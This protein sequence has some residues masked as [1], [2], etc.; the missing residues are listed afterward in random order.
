MKQMS[1]FRALKGLVTLALIA[2]GTSYASAQYYVNVMQ[3]DGTRIQ[4]S[5]DDIE[6]VSITDYKLPDFKAESVD[7]GLSVRWATC[8]IGANQANEKGWFVRWGETSEMVDTIPYKWYDLTTD[9]YTKYNLYERM[10]TVDMKYRL[11]AA[12]DV[13]NSGAGPQWRI[14]S[15][16]EFQELIDSCNWA[17]VDSGRV[18]GYLVTSKKNGNNIFL[19]TAGFSMNGNIYYPEHIGAYLSNTL[20]IV[21]NSE[22]RLLFFNLDTV[23]LQ[24]FSR[25]I[26]LSVR[27]VY[28]SDFGNNIL[29]VSGVELDTASL[30]LKAGQNYTLQ[31]TGKMPDNTTIK[32]GAVEWSTSDKNVAVVEDGQ[33]TAVGEGT[34]TITVSFGGKTASCAVAVIDPSKPQDPVD[35]GL[36][37]K[38]SKFNIGASAPYEFGDYYAWGETTTKAEYTWATYKYCNGSDTTLTK[39]NSDPKRGLNG[40]TDDKTVLDPDDDV[41]AVRWKGNWRMAYGREFKELI[42]SCDWEWT[43]LNGTYGYMVTSK[44]KGY[45]DQSIFLPAAGYINNGSSV[46]DIGYVGEYWAASLSGFGSQECYFWSGVYQLG[47][48][49]RS[50]GTTIRPVYTFDVA[51]V[52]GMMVDKKE[53]ALA[54]GGEDVVNTLFTDGNGRAISVNG[55]FTISWRSSNDNVATVNNGTVKAVGEG[56]CTITAICGSYNATCAVTVKDP[57]NVTPESVDLGLSVKWATFNLGAFAPE[58]LGDYYAWGEKEPYYEAGSAQSE[59]PVWK[60]GKE[61]GYVWANY[62]DTNDGGITFL[63]YSK[64]SGKTQ[65]DLEDDAAYVAWKGLWRIPSEAYFKELLDSCDWEETTLNGVGGYKVTSKVKGYEN[66]SIFLPF[67]GYR[68]TI[69][70]D[71]GDWGYY[72]SSTINVNDQSVRTLSI[73]EDDDISLYNDNRHWGQ[74]YRPVEFFSDANLQSVKLSTM[75]IDLGLNEKYALTLSGVMANGRTAALS[76]IVNWTSNKEAVAT[77]ADGV[78]KAVGTGIATITATYQNGQTKSC[79]VNVVD[80]YGI[81]AEYVNLGLSV[82]W[83]KYNLGAVRPDMYGD[84]FAWGAIEPYYEEGEGQ[85]LNPTWKDGYSD[86]YVWSDYF[87]TDDE[88]ESFNKYYQGALTTLEA[89]DDAAFN[90]WGDGWRL[91]TSTE[92]DELLNKCSWEFYTMNGV[93]GYL[94]TSMVKGYENNSI[95]LPLTGL[96]GEQT[97]YKTNGSNGGR[98]WTSTLYNGNDERARYLWIGYDDDPFM[99][100][101]PRDLGFTIRP[102]CNNEDYVDGP[103]VLTDNI[104]VQANDYVGGVRNEN[105]TPRTVND[106]DNYS[107]KCYIVTTNSD[108][109]S[110]SDAQLIITVDQDLE[111]GQIIN[112]SMRIKADVPQP[113]GTGIQTSSGEYAYYDP[114]G[115]LSF[116][117]EWMYFNTDY[118]V[119]NTNIKTFVFNLSFLEEGNNCYFD[120]ISVTVTDPFQGD[121]SLS[122]DSI[123]LEEGSGGFFLN[124]YDKN[125]NYD[126]FVVWS[127]SNNQIVNIT[128][129][130]YITAVSP[131]TAYITAEYRGVTKSCKVVVLP[132]E[133]VTTYVDLGLSVNWATCNIGA[134]TASD[135]GVYYAWGETKIK[136]NY[137]WS[138]YKYCNDGSSSQLTKYN[139]VSSYGYNSYVDDKTVL[140]SEDDVAAV[141]MGNGWHIPGITELTELY[142]K[143]TVTWTTLNGTQGCMFTSNVE[144]YEDKYIFVPAAGI[145]EDS[146]SPNRGYYAAMW[147]NSIYEDDTRNAYIASITSRYTEIEYADRFYGLSVRPVIAN[148]EWLGITSIEVD[149]VIISQYDGCDLN[150]TLLSGSEDYSFMTEGLSFESSNTNVV[151]VDESG[152]IIA[153]GPGVA[154]ITI[155]INKLSEECNVNVTASSYAP[156][157]QDNSRDYV[158]L[159]LSV[160]WATYNVGATT[161]SGRGDYFAWGE[162]EPYYNDGYAQSQ[163]ASWK[164]GKEEGYDWSSYFDSDDGQTYNKYDGNKKVL[165]IEDDAAN[166]NWGGNWRMPTD[167]EIE[168]LISDCTWTWTTMNGIGGYKVTSNKTGYTDRSIFLP[169][170]GLRVGTGLNSSLESNGYYWSSNGRML[171]FYLQGEGVYLYSSWRYYGQSVRPVCP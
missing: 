75:E 96:R 130:G 6:Q 149:D 28:S 106:P 66:N 144:G 50:I 124:A 115:S 36:S 32:L 136:T 145:R 101:N 103:I 87:D 139:N 15:I 72:W 40:F 13:A 140:D 81:D 135:E 22:C 147:L 19:P 17:L 59:T 68:D 39:Y 83:A 29:Q 161:P 110:N 166:V 154:T 99:S 24:A 112:F 54:P 85:S 121:F 94:V 30:K 163:Y 20:R 5:V 143:C 31:V 74:S 169:V 9:K 84:Y 151:T 157:G 45:T 69:E 8:N 164:N 4:Y 55:T 58:M 156:T 105:V 44:V 63:K 56:T 49:A 14:P 129:Y 131:G 142:E 119:S 88:G 38:W 12:D 125:Y 41:A 77:V 165:D 60:D 51:D 2:L 62:F 35:L 95:F 70:L 26:G 93:D 102:V 79:T 33:I 25:Q 118:M 11:D 108:Y 80:P 100:S 61:F 92:F 53:L 1:S 46:D 65:L 159:G 98:Y 7:L 111:P 107:N 134:K 152:H 86:G 27:P 133:P 127:S 52:K 16:E 146:Y 91:P 126:N 34:C 23:Y 42:D 104:T 132:L 158:D 78:V 97:L 123:S 48:W 167:A 170:A 117:R 82:N 57:A 122:K 43:T 120:E 116:G 168:E 153:V 90:L 148:E 160:K 10:G 150:V 47:S 76:G 141:L 3:K 162:T 71:L 67:A 109:D 73:Q 113:G 64:E 37:V 114:L 138:T 21:S 18:K 89:E 171:C 155:K 128:D 137:S